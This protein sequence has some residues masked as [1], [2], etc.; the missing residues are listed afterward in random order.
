M[1]KKNNSYHSRVASK[2]AHD[3]YDTVPDF[4]EFLP[5]FKDV[6]AAARAVVREEAETFELRRCL[7]VQPG[8]IP[9]MPSTGFDYIGADYYCDFAH[10]LGGDL[11]ACLRKSMESTYEAY[12]QEFRLGRLHKKNKPAIDTGCGRA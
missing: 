9:L 7:G 1:A 11:R 6:L 3:F 2:L 8:D 10:D 5:P 4:R 12:A